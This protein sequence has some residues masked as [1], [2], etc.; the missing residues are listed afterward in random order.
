M[1]ID[2]KDCGEGFTEKKGIL[3]WLSK[4]KQGFFLKGSQDQQKKNSTR[5]KPFSFNFE[6]EYNYQ[7]RLTTEALS[8]IFRRKYWFL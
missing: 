4:S 1:T 3:G 8:T 5:K 6:E 7:C 2:L